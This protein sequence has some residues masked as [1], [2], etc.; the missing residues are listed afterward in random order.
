M[1]LAIPSLLLAALLPLVA[2]P[3]SEANSP[4]PRP[5]V[6][7]LA[8]DDLSDWV[9]CLEGHPDA[10]TPNIDRLAE[11]GVLF[12]HAYCVSPICGPSRASVLTGQ[13][14]ETTG[15]YT[16]RGT[17]IDHVP[18]AVSLPRRMQQH[19]YRVLGAG[20]VNHGLGLRIPE[21]WHE[22]G[23]GSGVVGSPFTDEEL[24]CEG[25]LPTREIRRD[26]WRCTLPMNGGLSM[27]DRP[28]NQWDTF[29]WGPLDVPEEEFPDARVA[30]WGARQLALER[31]QPL[32][33]A[34][35]IYK[36]HQPF[37]VPRAYFERFSAE[38]VHL[39]P[40]LAGD[41]DDVP[42]AGRDLALRPW[43]SGTHR[44]VVEH[45]AW[46]EAVAA[47]LATIAFAD[48]QVGVVVD[49]LS[50]SERADDTWVVLWSD[51]GWSLGQKEHWG[52]HDP[53]RSSLRVPLV[54]V[55]PVG[56]AP[57]GFRP[58]TVCE[59]PVSLL[60]LYPTVLD[61]CELPV[62]DEL[63]GR[64]LLPL[65]RDPRAPWPEAVVS[66]VGRGTHSVSTPEWR[67][68][69]YFDGSEEL[70]E[71]ESDPQE[72]FNRAD[73]PELA[74]VRERLASYTPRD[75]R[76]LRYVRR[77]R[78]KC[79]LRADG[80]ANLFDLHA[81]MG[82]SEQDDLAA[83]RPEVVAEIRAQLERLELEE[84]FV[85][86][87]DPE[88]RPLRVVAFGD[89]TTAPR[90]TVREVYAARLPALLAEE[91]IEVEV[92]NR[93]RG[94]SHTGRRSDNAVD[95]LLADDSRIAPIGPA[96]D[97]RDAQ[98]RV[99][100][101]RLAPRELR[102]VVPEVDHQRVLGAPRLLQLV[103]QEAHAGIEA[104]E[105]VVVVR[106]ELA[107]PRGV[108][109]DPRQRP[110][111]VASDRFRGQTAVLPQQREVCVGVV[112][113]QEERRF[114]GLLEETRRR[115]GDAP[116]VAA[117][118]GRRL[119]LVEAE[120]AGERR[121]GVDV[122]PLLLGEELE[123]GRPLHW[124]YLASEEGPRALLREG[125]WIVGAGWDRPGQRMGRV[126]LDGIRTMR[127]A[128]LAGFQLWN[129]I[130]DVGQE[131]D[132]AAREPER[133]AVMQAALSTLHREVVCEA[134]DWPTLVENEEQ[135]DEE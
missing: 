55:P 41:L 105:T 124:H 94:G 116:H 11:R 61:A 80:T 76:V 2:L 54:V 10:H 16:N 115:L 5:D 57:E 50:R 14:P 122:T 96:E 89:S 129:V 59:A 74:E 43:T 21:D 118:E 48:A 102:A 128:E 51:H 82:I 125:D 1:T 6:L 99:V 75:D 120:V 8:V 62:P 18:D 113:H 3:R 117:V 67:Y 45:D 30:A 44:T 98:P 81:P 87:P 127:A 20:K 101:R 103:E 123:R 69:R 26:G 119:A 12:T 39:P 56:R 17:Y 107:Q 110:D 47:Y 28:T 95:Q 77:G 31:D 97:Q 27:I 36:P 133:L 25:M 68:I 93:G 63:E 34:I 131:N 70:Y 88:D 91:G 32:F 73:E 42:I 84:R 90:K 71:L 92:L 85:A 130:D 40:A 100:H 134:P 72:F 65:L 78:W 38:E 104:G 35:G 9:G 126:T 106:G 15:V 66:T 60:D 52:K 29:D 109:A 112:D 58:G 64:S 7:F 19:G 83:K 37:F 132:L 111:L 24:R 33:L 53:W 86:L 23:P 108:G 46:R 49:A 13:R 22:Y 4:E 121:L 114:P 135:E 79:V